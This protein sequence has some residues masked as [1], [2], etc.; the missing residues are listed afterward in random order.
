MKLLAVFPKHSYGDPTRE[1]SYE[2]V[3]FYDSFLQMGIEVK[4]FDPLVVQKSVG[5]EKM[6]AALL[7]LAG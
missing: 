5:K 4:H 1:E 6:N 3:H 7:E 2:Y